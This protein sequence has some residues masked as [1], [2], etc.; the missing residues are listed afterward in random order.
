[1][2][3]CDLKVRAKH[4]SLLQFRLINVQLTP[5]LKLLHLLYL[6]MLFFHRLCMHWA[7]FIERSALLEN[8]LSNVK[9]T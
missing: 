7:L 5:H 4:L 9:L 6:M 8:G 1:M 3:S 2:L